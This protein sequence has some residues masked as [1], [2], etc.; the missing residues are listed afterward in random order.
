MTMKIECSNCGKQ[1]HFA[2]LICSNDECKSILIDSK[3]V[4]D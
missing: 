2:N 3:L 1:S 4:K